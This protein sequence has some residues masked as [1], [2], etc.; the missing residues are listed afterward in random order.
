MPKPT[1]LSNLLEISLWAV[2]WGKKKNKNIDTSVHLVWCWCL[3][4]LLPKKLFQS[5]SLFFSSVE[6]GA[7]VTRG[8]H[9]FSVPPSLLWLQTGVNSRPVDGLFPCLFAAGH[10]VAR[11]APP[12][13]RRREGLLKSW[14]WGGSSFLPVLSRTLP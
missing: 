8:H 4:Q 10:R 13:L 6:T 12:V 2:S 9:P 7:C 14:F 1:K 5:F 11:T 3:L